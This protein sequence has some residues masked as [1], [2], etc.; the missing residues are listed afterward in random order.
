VNVQLHDPSALPPD[1]LLKQGSGRAPDPIRNLLLDEY[2]S[3]VPG[4]RR[5]EREADHSLP[6]SS[7][8]KNE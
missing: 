2:R 7:E 4:I 5:S 6:S 3:S 1:K 8:L